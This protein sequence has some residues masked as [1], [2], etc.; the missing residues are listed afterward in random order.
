MTTDR[1]EVRD[2]IVHAPA[3]RVRVRESNRLLPVQFVA[4]DAKRLRQLDA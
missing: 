3:A 1:A 2:G 4:S